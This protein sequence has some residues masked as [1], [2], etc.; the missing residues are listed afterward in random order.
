M[1]QQRNP[2][3]I[4]SQ[5]TSFSVESWPY[6]GL[7][8]LSEVTL[9]PA[10][11]HLN[12]QRSFGPDGF[13]AATAEGFLMLPHNHHH[14]HHLSPSPHQLLSQQSNPPH[15]HHQFP[16][17]LQKQQQHLY[18]SHL[19]HLS[20]D[21]T[22]AWGNREKALANGTLLLPTSTE[23]AAAFSPY[24]VQTGWQAAQLE[25]NAVVD[26]SNAISP[27]LLYQMP[28]A[29]GSESDCEVAAGSG[30][31][32]GGSQLVDPSSNAQS[33][34]SFGV[35][36][37]AQCDLFQPDHHQQQQT[38]PS[39]G[40]SWK[41]GRKR[42]LEESIM[43]LH[44]SA[45][46]AA[47]R[48]SDEE[49]REKEVNNEEEA[50]PSI[51][52]AKRSSSPPDERS[53]HPTVK[54]PKREDKEE[55]CQAEDEGDDDFFEGEEPN[56]EY[57]KDDKEACERTRMVKVE[58][59]VRKVEVTAE[60]N[61]EAHMSLESDGYRWRKYGR[62]TVK[63]SPFPR[64]YFKCTFPHCLV[65]KQVEAVIKNGH[66]VSMTSIYKGKHSH[67]RPC[68]THITAN[69][70][71]S[72]RTAVISGS[73]QRFSP[74]VPGSTPRLVITTESNVDYLDDGYRWR[75]YG[76][77]YV[78]GSGFPRSYYKCTDKHCPVKKQVDSLASGM[79]VTYE[80]TH[81]HEPDLE[82]PLLN[83]RRRR[84]GQPSTVSPTED[85]TQLLWLKLEPVEE[86]QSADIISQAPPCG[87]ISTIKE[88]PSDAADPGHSSNLP[89]GVPHHHRMSCSSH[90]PAYTG[91]L[92][93]PLDNVAESE[94][95]RGGFG[96]SSDELMELY[97][98]EENL[99]G[100]LFSPANTT[101]L[102]SSLDGSLDYFFRV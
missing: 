97:L 27:S 98:W 44:P 75:K 65:K 72:F 6:G 49:K 52:A 94:A 34:S 51:K 102:E 58:R 100:S 64:S 80:G 8:T 20:V 46:K 41:R 66:I 62:K 25:T 21:W 19:H 33:P 73:S 22:F 36:A 87:P 92:S 17:L 83:K 67:E 63:G 93:F 24:D 88:E 89:T 10:P 4:Y 71:D 68:V 31:A 56:G 39:L 28:L 69:D 99:L 12:L 78:K 91:P 79:I 35:C 76:Q 42:K 60:L 50:D 7:T 18:H 13:T 23:D 30:P 90:V 16:P 53:L 77:K 14:H 5:A 101:C 55:E 11:I 38:L 86:C 15:Q 85:K 48:D 82:K 26:L 95:S 57:S 74:Q 37:L 96:R 59:K 1:H 81:T 84:E 45:H 40:I 61:I 3:T 32:P 43:R 29:P 9:G 54:E 2:P 47:E 70:Q